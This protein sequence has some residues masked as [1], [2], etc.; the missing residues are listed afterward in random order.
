[1]Q[2]D[3]AQALQI[4]TDVLEY[5]PEGPI[6]DLYCGVGALTLLAAKRGHKVLGV[7][8]DR[9]AI[10]LAKKSA[11]ENG[12]DAEFQA[13]PCEQIAKRDIQGFDQ[14]IVNPPRTGLSTQVVE[15]IMRQKPKR[16]VYI[17][18]NPATLARDTKA[19]YEN[20]YKIKKGQVYDMFAETTHLETVLYFER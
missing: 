12:L 8:L 1:M 11:K 2:N 5:M 14:W 17:S 18:C 9:E 10:E 19:F 20:G 15:I 13:K 4:Y 3:P 7:E 6:L 16:V